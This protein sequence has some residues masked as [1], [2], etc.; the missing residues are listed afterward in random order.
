MKSY[1]ESNIE[2]NINCKLALDICQISVIADTLGVKESKIPDLMG[3]AI[4]NPKD[5]KLVNKDQA[6]VLENC[7]SNPNLLDLPTPHYFPIDAGKYL[8]S[9]MV[10]VMDEGISNASFHR[11]L[12][13]EDNKMV[14][15]IVPRHL[16]RILQKNRNTTCTL[17]IRFK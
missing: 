5:P 12:I 11:M 8:T 7:I 4:E 9:A 14:A 1:I 3:D 13:L 2:S 10:F 17:T 15:R 6:S 16:H